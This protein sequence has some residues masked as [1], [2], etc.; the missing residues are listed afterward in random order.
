MED[1]LGPRRGGR[2]RAT[3]RDVL[4]KRADGRAEGRKGEKKVAV[5]GGGGRGVFLASAVAAEE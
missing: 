4:M 5:A 3:E 1:R 2:A